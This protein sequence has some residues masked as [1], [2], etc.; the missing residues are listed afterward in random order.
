MLGRVISTLGVWGMIT[1]LCGYLISTVR[2][3]TMIQVGEQPFEVPSF[4][5]GG[6][7]QGTTTIMAPIFQ[8]VTETM[9]MTWQLIV[10]ALTL[11]LILGAIRATMSIWENNIDQ[12]AAAADGSR[13]MKRE[14][15]K[16]MR[17]LLS[18]M[19]DEEQ[20]AALE[21]LEAERIGEDGERVSMAELLQSRR[22]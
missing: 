3:T 8:T 13:K 1:L 17:R 7:E 14:Q 11:V 20:L 4:A 6:V 22:G 10:A 19:D 18:R 12:R 2:Y 9:P 21:A 15:E 5:A 16:R